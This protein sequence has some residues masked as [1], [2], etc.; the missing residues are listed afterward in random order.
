MSNETL[1]N[2]MSI[3]RV[4]MEEKTSVLCALPKSMDLSGVDS[5]GLKLLQKC[6]ICGEEKELDKFKKQFGR[7]SDTCKLCFNER[8]YSRRITYKGK[9]IYLEENPRTNVCPIC[10]KT[11]AENHGN[12]MSVHHKLYILD[13]PLAFTAERCM[14]CHG[15]ERGKR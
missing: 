8:H 2:S 1:L 11:K 9:R 12:Q 14:S 13:K 10:G 3:N 6:R 5:L 15:K 7:L 4:S